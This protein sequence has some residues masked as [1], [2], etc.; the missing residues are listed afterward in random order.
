MISNCQQFSLDF[1][2]LCHRGQYRPIAK[3]NDNRRKEIHALKTTIEEL[4][5]RP[6]R[7]YTVLTECCYS[8]KTGKIIKNTKSP[9]PQTIPQQSNPLPSQPQNQITRHAI[10]TPEP[11]QITHVQNVQN[12]TQIMVNVTPSASNT[13]AGGEAR[14]SP[15]IF[16]PINTSTPIVRTINRRTI[17][18]PRN[19]IRGFSTSPYANKQAMSLQLNRTSEHENMADYDYCNNEWGPIQ[20]PGDMFGRRQLPVAIF[21]ANRTVNESDSHDSGAA[22]TSSDENQMAVDDTDEEN[23]EAQVLLDEVDADGSSDDISVKDINVQKLR[24][25]NQVWNSKAK[26]KRS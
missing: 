24:E 20:V 13:L 11:A 5:A 15:L 14:N 2:P 12:V 3:V 7:M 26:P 6:D 4:N 9:N 17:V 10:R 16:Q 23:D 25:L 18:S 19:K 21:D 22:K 1:P 8:G